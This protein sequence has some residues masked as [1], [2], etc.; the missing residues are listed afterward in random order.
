MSLEFIEFLRRQDVYANFDGEVVSC[1]EGVIKPNPKIYRTLVSRY[2]LNPS[3]TLFIDDRSAN[4]DVARS[5]GWHG[6]HFST[7]SAKECCEELRN[8]L[9]E[10]R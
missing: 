4:I 1:E 7:R 6:Y 3:E 8:M 9:I 10:S 2:N 5:E